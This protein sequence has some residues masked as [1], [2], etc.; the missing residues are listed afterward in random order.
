ML[1]IIHT[2]D[3]HV[4][5]K[6][7]EEARK[8]LSFLVKTVK[9]EKP[10]LV[11]IAGDIWNSENVKLDSLSA[12]LVFRIVTELADVAP[13][14]CITGTKSH[15]GTASEALR[16]IYA[17]NQV[18]VSTMPE[19]IYLM[20]DKSFTTDTTDLLP[21]LIISSIP[22]PTKQ[23]FQ[24]APGADIDS[25]NKEIATTMSAILGG[26]GAKV[27]KHDCSHVLIGHFSIGGAFVADNQQLL[28]VDIELS[29]DQ[30]D[31]ASTSLNML[32]HI[33]Y[34]QCLGDKK[35]F[36]SGDIFQSDFGEV[37]QEKGFY[38]H[39]IDDATGLLSKSTFIPT[40][41]THL[42]KLTYDLTDPQ[43]DFKL[44]FTQENKDNVKDAVVKVEIKVYEDE[45]TK[46]DREG[47]ERN[48]SEAKSHD[49]KI[50]RCPRENVRSENIL[51]LTKLR[52][53]LTEM[54]RLKNEEVP[55][56]I[57]TKADMLE[58]MEGDEIVKNAA[59]CR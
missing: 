9:T 15:D 48:L 22:T 41:Y 40:P 42:Y 4:D 12:K 5:D 55:E 59:T 56:S 57:L 49:I 23:Y 50:I 7:I 29:T 38:L 17:K 24:S 14:F 51:K 44:P 45:V 36:Y 26:F 31:L 6:N 54:A 53:K 10:D 52:E 2:A 20:H 30:L 33:H 58:S 21:I 39:E 34:A 46:I 27:Q 18:F 11:A 8:C 1:R 25:T 32:G 35:T 47:L 43:T 19:Q 28:G 13:V 3:F 37:G 16:Y